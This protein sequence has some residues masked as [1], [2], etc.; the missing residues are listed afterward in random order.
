MTVHCAIIETGG[1]LPAYW[2]DGAFGTAWRVA[3]ADEFTAVWLPADCKPTYM[4]GVA[5]LRAVITAESIISTTSSLT[6]EPPRLQFVGTEM[7]P[8]IQQLYLRRA[9]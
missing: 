4:N 7:I 8:A 1:V 9:E 3:G 5:T 2:L 6:I